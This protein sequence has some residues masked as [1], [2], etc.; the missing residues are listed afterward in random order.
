MKSTFHDMLNN[1][2]STNN[3]VIEKFDI[4]KMVNC[5]NSFF[6]VVTSLNFKKMTWYCKKTTNYAFFC[7]Y[8]DKNFGLAAFYSSS[9]CLSFLF[10]HDS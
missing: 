1:M 5:Q 3:I 8:L 10:N 4:I 9:N 6:S 2:L 7:S